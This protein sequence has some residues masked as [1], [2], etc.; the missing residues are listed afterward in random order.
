MFSRTR[1]YQYRRVQRA[2]SKLEQ[3]GNVYDI[4]VVDDAFF[5]SCWHLKDWIRND[6]TLSQSTRHAIVQEAEKTE[7]LNFC[8]DLANR[9][10]HFKLKHE[11]KGAT[12]LHIES[13]STVNAKTGEVQSRVPIGF[14]IASK[15][16]TPTPYTVIGFAIRAV[17]DW[18]A[19]LRK[20]G[21]VA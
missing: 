8:A 10:K 18:T 11:R 20:H 1:Q 14:A 16:G 21:L 19:L 13:V 17:Q 3:G 9:S 6:C 2:L 4:H 5:E 15:R 12:L 7:S